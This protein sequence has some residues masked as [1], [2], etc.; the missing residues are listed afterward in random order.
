MKLIKVTQILIKK[1]TNINPL[2]NLYSPGR[3]RKIEKNYILKY[4]LR[5]KLFAIEGIQ[6]IHVF[7]NSFSYN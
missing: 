1:L 6:L 7:F 5:Q 2:N 4:N 3:Y